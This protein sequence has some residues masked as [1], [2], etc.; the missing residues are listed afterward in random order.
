MWIHFA[1]SL[2]FYLNTFRGVKKRYHNDAV[3]LIVSSGC[4]TATNQLPNTR[5]IFPLCF[6]IAVSNMSV[7]F[8]GER[9]TV[10]KKSPHPSEGKAMGK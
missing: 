6:N 3:G 4:V 7:A 9:M 1:E 10:R 8:R 5:I 2:S